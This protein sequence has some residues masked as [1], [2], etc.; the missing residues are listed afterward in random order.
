[1]THTPGPWKTEG[2]QVVSPADDGGFLS[3]ALVSVRAEEWRDNALLIAAAPDLLAACTAAL[4]RIES[5][6]SED[7][8]EAIILRAAI[9]KAK[10]E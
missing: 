10:G 3:V 1:V 2:P 9:M 5:D 8:D 4:A 6:I 7:C